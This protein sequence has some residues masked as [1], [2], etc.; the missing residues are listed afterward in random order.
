MTELKPECQEA[1]QVLYSYLDNELTTELR[2]EIQSHL[3]DCYPCLEAFEFEV[4][5][6]ALIQR[7]CRD[8]VPEEFMHRLARL[9]EGETTT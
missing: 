2:Q 4:E 3:D 8:R 6:R 5:L 1:V 9:L 7:K